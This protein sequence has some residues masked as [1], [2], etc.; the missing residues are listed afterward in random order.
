LVDKSLL[1]HT[2]ER[3]WMLETIREFARERV[4]DEM[5]RRH[6]EYFI[7]LAKE[8][9]PNLRGDPGEWLE[10]LD[11]EQDNFRATLDWLEATGQTQLALVLCAKVGLF[12]H[13]RG[14]YAEGTRRLDRVLAVDNRR[15]AARAEAPRAGARM[16]ER[17]GE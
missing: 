14:L 5:R 9:H 7:A 6:A 2:R 4:S 17:A 16:R 11:R 8:A 12:W 1:R 3:Y 13:Q 10:R 15:S